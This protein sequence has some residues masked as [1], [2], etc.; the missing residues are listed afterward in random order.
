MCFYIFCSILILMYRV[1]A[2]DPTANIPQ[3]RIV[4]IKV[5]TESSLTPVE[6]F[7]GI[8]YANAPLGRFRFSAPERHPGWRR[9]FF[10]HR[11]PPRCPQLGLDAESYNEDCLFLNIFAPKRVDG[12][13]LPVMV[14]LYSETWLQGGATLP[15]QE[16]ASEGVVVITV[17]YRL[18][19]LS[20]F[21]LN[22]VAAR[23]NLALLDQYLALLWTR[24]NIAAFGGD[25]NAITLVGHSAGA[26][27]VL[28]H[29]VSP[30]SAGLFHRAII[31]SP[32]N[33]WRAIDTGLNINATQ[34][35]RISRSIAEALECS[36]TTDREILNCMRS[37]SITDIISAALNSTWLNDLQ[38][39]SDNFLPES[40]QYLPVSVAEALTSSKMSNIQLDVLM[41]TTNLEAINSN[42]HAYEDLMKEGPQRIFEYATTRAI[43][44]TLRLLSLQ[45]EDTLSMLIQMIRWEFWGV[46][47]RKE[48]E[49]EAIAAVEGLARMESSARWGAG[50][51][52]LAERLARRALRLYVYRF[53]QPSQ[54]DIRGRHFNFTGAVHGADLIALLGDALMLQIARRPATDSEK[55]ISSVFRK[56]I[57]NF[58]RFGYPDANDGWE[59]YKVGNAY[60]QEIREGF[61]NDHNYFSASRDVAFWLKYLPNL[62]NLLNSRE[63]SE[64][65][66]TEEDGSRLRGGMV[67]MSAVSVVLLLLLCAAAGLLHWRRTRR[68]SLHDDVMNHH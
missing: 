66:T 18:H 29:I 16:L 11:M 12:K 35:E 10:A 26:D 50:G 61:N 57:T 67:A 28:H 17:N 59:R 5:Y 19:L 51:A 49:K 48:V 33:M 42:D 47:S 25:P 2:Q 60:V 21:T 63:H 6:I 23:G 68:F 65:F 41:G 4:G 34:V 46:Q 58:V 20:L 40:E 14:L 30:R 24:E 36:G 54:V 7:Y 15:C 9:T 32:R 1:S 43:P 31:M 37:R 45:R 22:S 62:S 56:Y 38:P 27:C 53:S 55:R 52:L 44:E 64:Q 39:I 3:G 8:P 13:L